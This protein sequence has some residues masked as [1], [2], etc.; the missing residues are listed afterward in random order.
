MRSP[1][2]FSLAL[3]ALLLAAAPPPALPALVTVSNT[4]L[5]RTALG[6]PVQAQDGNIANA[7]TPA[8][9]FLLVGMSYGLCPYAGCTN[10]TLGA[11]GFSAGR[12][13]AYTSP[14]LGDGTWSEPTELLPA[15]LRPANAI[16]FRPHL[17]F[18]PS[19]RQWVLWVRWLPYVSPSL[20]KDSTLY[21]VAA[22]AS[23][24]G[25]FAVVNENVTM[26][27]PNS[28]DDNLYVA[29]D[30]SGYLVHTARAQS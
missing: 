27:W 22:S 24:L 1:P 5:R 11:C 13:L 26:F 14:T 6:H 15:A 12:I 21:L 9:D 20:A 18:N 10:E 29:P 19:T 28:A 30:G 25:P 3:L 17:V 16:Y 23:P 7:P 8:G 2:H 4:A